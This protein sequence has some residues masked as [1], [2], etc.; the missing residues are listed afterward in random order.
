MALETQGVVLEAHAAAQKTKLVL[1]INE[2][3][4]IAKCLTGE[5]LE[6]PAEAKHLQH[7][8][9]N[10]RIIND[11]LYKGASVLPCCGAY[12]DPANWEVSLDLLE[13]NRVHAITTMA[14]YAAGVAAADKKKIR[15]LKRVTNPATMGK[16][17]S[18][19]KEPYIITRVT[20]AGSYYI[21]TP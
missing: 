9:R 15:V 19:W 20:R 2:A 16:L 3:H 21:A 14:G 8:V 4:T 13:E 18:K 10:Y 1:L 7:C 6:D 11:L 5:E 12:R 17:G